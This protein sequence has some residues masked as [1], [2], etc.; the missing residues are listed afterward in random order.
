MR[1]VLIFAVLI[2]VSWAQ[3]APHAVSSSVLDSL[4]LPGEIASTS[5]N[6]SSYEK[7]NVVADTYVEQKAVISSAWNE[8]LTITPYVSAEFVLDTSGYNWNNKVSPSFGLKINKHLPAGIIS[9]GVGYMY[10]NRFRN[11]EGFQ[12]ASGRTDFLTDWFGWNNMA[13]K[14]NRFP[15]STWGIIGHFSPVEKGNLI[16]RSYLQQGYV[17]HRF[18]AIAVV[19]FAE[20][21]VGHDSKRYDWE[22]I[23]IVGTG[24]KAGLPAGKMY[25]EIGAGYLRETRLISD[26]TSQGLKVFVNIWSGWSLFGRK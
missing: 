18:G 16:E 14:A 10:E 5:G 1:Q 15:G 22:N 12:P 3:D 13:E 21:T 11:A 19:P 9:A 23:A 20:A 4:K 6:L 25:T 7:G 8:T 17:L 24:V 26:R 2:S